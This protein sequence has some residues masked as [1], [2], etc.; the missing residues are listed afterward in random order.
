MT[1]PRRKPP[2]K[3]KASARHKAPAKRKA[4]PG[5]KP[6]P[7]R[8]T[9]AKP[10]LP[11]ISCIQR[12]GPL[13]VW[14]VDGAYIRK[15]V[16]EEFSNFGHHFS[17]TRIPKNEIWIDQETHPDEQQFF[18]R[19]AIVERRLLRTGMDYEKARLLANREERKMRV[20]AGDLKKVVRGNKLPDARLV[21]RELWK[22]LTNGVQVWFVEGRLVRSV[23][24]ID[25]T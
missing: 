17:F 2:A 12:R 11:H 15:N 19:H 8:A 25:F 20:A 3:R 9:S 4:K 14:L 22:T 6:R 10:R 13:S 18:I 21:H 5:R 16:D 7:P 1:A 24:D 23:Y